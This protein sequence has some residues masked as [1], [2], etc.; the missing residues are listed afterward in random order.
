MPGILKRANSAFII[1]SDMTINQQ[2]SWMLVC[3]FCAVHTPRSKI[4]WACR[5]GP[6]A[7]SCRVNRDCTSKS[8]LESIHCQ[9]I[10]VRSLDF[11]VSCS[12]YSNPNFFLHWTGLQVPI[13]GL[14]RAC[15]FF[16]FWSCTKVRGPFKTCSHQDRKVDGRNIKALKSQTGVAKVGV[17]DRNDPANVE[18]AGR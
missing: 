12:S 11:A 5:E 3:W 13:E 15:V 2:Y 4:C 16:G 7:V 9:V 10:P 17:L 6:E 1:A 8:V 18:I 14:V